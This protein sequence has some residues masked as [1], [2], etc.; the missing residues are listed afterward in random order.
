MLI[1]YCPSQTAIMSYISIFN[2]HIKIYAGN[3]KK[4]KKLCIKKN[5]RILNMK[6]NFFPENWSGDN[7]LP[8]NHLGPSV[9]V[10]T[11]SILPDKMDMFL[12]YATVPGYM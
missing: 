1:I 9:A 8:R 10:E 11:K 6:F 2:F 5:A 4:L 3:K 7:K 12:A